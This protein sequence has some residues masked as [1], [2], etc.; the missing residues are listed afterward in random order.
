MPQDLIRVRKRHEGQAISG[1]VA[2]ACPLGTFVN[3]DPD[4]LATPSLELATGTKAFSLQRAVIDDQGQGIPLQ[5]LV[6][7]NSIIINPELINNFV[8]AAKLIEAEVEGPTLLPS[9]L[10]NSVTAET[11]AGTELTTGNGGIVVR[12]ED[13]ELYGIC[14]GQLTPVDGGNPARILIQFIE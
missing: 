6:F 2:F 1:K 5:N 9:G 8:T 10:D 12:G 11:E 3:Y 13:D 14:R 7:P 4:D